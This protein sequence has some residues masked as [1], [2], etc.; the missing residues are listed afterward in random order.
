[1]HTGSKIGIEASAKIVR[2]RVRAMRENVAFP[3]ERE[4][5]KRPDLGADSASIQTSL[6]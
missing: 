4:R 2:V 5:A 3:R 1:M 6:R